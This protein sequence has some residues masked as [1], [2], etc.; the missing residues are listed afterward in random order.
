MRLILFLNSWGGREVA[1]WLRDRREEIAGLVV[2]PDPDQ[3]F[4]REIVQELNLPADQTWLGPQLKLPETLARIRELQPDLGIS[5]WFAYLLRPELLQLFKHGCINLHPAYLPWNRGWHT[6][7]WPIIDGTPAGVTVHYI[8]PGVDTGDIIVQKR[9]PVALNDT[10]GTLHQKLNNEMLALFKSAWPSIREGKN[11]RTPQ[12]HSRATHHRRAEL[13]SLDALDLEKSCPAGQL[14]NLLRARTY[15]PY[16]S[17]FYL[18]QGE[19]VYVR[20]QLSEPGEPGGEAPG[21]VRIE[22]EREYPVGELL[23]L[24]RP[25]AGP[26]PHYIQ[27]GKRVYV[28]AQLLGLQE[29]DSSGIPPW[30]KALP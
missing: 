21:S 19:K 18:Q 20:L 6:N 17:A 14:L 29:L 9:V 27:Q 5:A 15:P 7:M 30:M 25:S 2:Q 8:D 12:D 23:R 10:G 28:S 4:A 3:R 1:K 13:S 26:P 22:L 11:T 24:L 16:P